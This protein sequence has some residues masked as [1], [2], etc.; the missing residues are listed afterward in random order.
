MGCLHVVRVVE[1]AFAA[2]AAGAAPAAAAQVAAAAGRVAAGGAAAGAGVLAVPLRWGDTGRVT[3]V[4]ARSCALPPAAPALRVDTHHMEAWGQGLTHEE[5]AT[6][7]AS[8]DT[9]R[10]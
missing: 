8:W 2:G 1:A 7:P 4:P 3:R 10:H 9:T 5:R 6:W